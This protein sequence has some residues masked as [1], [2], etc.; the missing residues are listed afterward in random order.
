MGEEQWRER[1]EKV[2]GPSNKGREEMNRKGGKE[3][4]EKRGRKGRDEGGGMER[5]TTTENRSEERKVKRAVRTVRDEKAE[6]EEK[7]NKKSR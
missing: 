6:G 3:G 7:D 1:C 5:V 4:G 2:V